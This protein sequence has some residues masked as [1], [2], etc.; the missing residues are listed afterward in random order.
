MCFD[1]QT[2]ENS[3]ITKPISF[4][5]SL[6]SKK[7]K[8]YKTKT[9]DQI[10]GD[11][12]CGVIK[13]DVGG[14]EISVLH[15]AIQTIK[16]D[17]PNLLLNFDSKNASLESILDLLDE[18]DYEAFYMNVHSSTSVIYKVDKS[19]KECRETFM[20]CF[21]KD[22]PKRRFVVEELEGVGV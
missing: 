22:D 17:S 3:I 12:V 18:L 11:R 14:Y 5:K 2:N 15:G 20:M 4:W 13:I 8:R 9:L 6:F 21:H 10:I 1:R 7:A 19:C 16:R